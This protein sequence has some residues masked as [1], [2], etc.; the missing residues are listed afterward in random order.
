MSKRPPMNGKQL[1][2]ARRTIERLVRSKRAVTRRKD[3][4][5]TPPPPEPT[6]PTPPDDYQQTLHVPCNAAELAALDKIAENER[7]GLALGGLRVKVSR[8][9][10][11]RKAIAEYAKQLTTG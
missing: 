7:R 9:A 5:T 3:K 2:E 6:P 4:P 10:A 1:N 11:A 8:V